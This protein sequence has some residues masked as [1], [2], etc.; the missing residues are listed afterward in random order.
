M[1]LLKAN[2]IK[3]GSELHSKLE[4]RLTVT[5]VNDLGEGQYLYY[6][7]EEIVVHGQL[8]HVRRLFVCK[9]DESDFDGVGWI[10]N[11]DMTECMVCAQPFG[12]FRWHHHCRCCGNLV[13]NACSP[14]T[15]VIQEFKEQGEVRVCIQCYWGQDPVSANNFKR[16]SFSL[17]D[18]F[19]EVVEE[20]YTD[21]EL[22]G[23]D[24]SN[25]PRSKID[26]ESTE[27]IVVMPVPAFVVKTKRKLNFHETGRMNVQTT[28]TR[29][30]FI[31]VCLHSCVPY[32]TN[33][34]Q[35]YIC[36][37]VAVCDVN[38]GLIRPKEIFLSEEPDE[39][40]E[41]SSVEEGKDKDAADT[42]DADTSVESSPRLA[43]NN[44]IV[45]EECDFTD[46][47]QESISPISSGKFGNA[48]SGGSGGVGE[49]ALDKTEL[50]QLLDG[51]VDFE[52]YHVIVDPKVLRLC[53]NNDPEINK[54]NELLTARIVKNIAQKFQLS[55]A[56]KYE[57]LDDIAYQGSSMAVIHIPCSP[58]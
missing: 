32:C 12:I 40:D 45:E 42:F 44:T 58:Q 54:R 28:L 5:D 29:K 18:H 46:R 3:P 50:T 7:D 2:V 39:D 41:E 13:C 24:G 38:G 26:L 51:G 22:G 34:G 9:D 36:E 16:N 31:N 6:E 33:G 11:E 8:R 52:V 27:K 15:A 53:L 17:N 49:A 57:I 35:Y 14:E 55:L 23:L 43:R 10:I 20:Y 56:R 1:E 30:V 47:S 25:T 48:T 21:H 19:T 4:S 37:D